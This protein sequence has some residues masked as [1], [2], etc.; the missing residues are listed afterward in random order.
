[1]AR[2]EQRGFRSDAIARPVD[3]PVLDVARSPVA[4]VFAS[5]VRSSAERRGWSRV[6]VEVHRAESWEGDACLPFNLVSLLLRPSQRLDCRLED[7]PAHRLRPV[8]GDVMIIPAGRAHWGAWQGHMDFVLAY[9]AP[10]V[11]VQTVRDDGF[12]T[13]RS[14]LVYRPQAR[15]AHL[16]SLLLALHSELVG[17]G[18]EDRLYVDTLAVQLAIRLLQ[19][20][21]TAPLQLREYRHGLSRGKMRL[22]LDYLNTYMNRNIQLAEL[23]DL[24]QMSQFHFLRLFRASC[25]TTPHRYLVER[26]VEVA[27]SLLLQ[28]DMSLA[29]VAYRLGFADQSHFSRHFRRIT[30]APPGRLRRASRPAT[31]S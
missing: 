6:L 28:D 22:V 2:S 15:D 21:G 3:Q 31:G 30:G 16:A 24:V 19:G 17:P 13:D 18:E 1:M 9:L 11:L 20:H 26:R 10:E 5:P 23:A 4:D 29:E 7:G 27:K 14:E 12:D 25:G 8:V